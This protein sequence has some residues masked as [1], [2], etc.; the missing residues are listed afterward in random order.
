MTFLRRAANK[1][2]AVKH[3]ERAAMRDLEAAINQAH[4]KG[5]SQRSIAHEAG[6]DRHT[7]ARALGKPAPSR[8]RH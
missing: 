3:K 8:K 6:V 7:V 4:N 5:Q 1:W 2:R